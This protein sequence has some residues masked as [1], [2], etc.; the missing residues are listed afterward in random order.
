MTVSLPIYV[1]VRLL[2][3]VCRF[4]SR[5]NEGNFLPTI[6]F[7]LKT[8]GPRKF[9]FQWHSAVKNRVESIKALIALG[10]H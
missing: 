6:A 3:F 4:T 2:L 10:A 7:S 8:K 1:V 5:K 9:I